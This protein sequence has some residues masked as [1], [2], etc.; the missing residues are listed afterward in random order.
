M[1]EAL[2]GGEWSAAHPG[3]TLSPGKTRYPLYRRLG[4]PQGRSGRA[5]N[6]IL[7]GIRSRTLQPVVQSLYRLSYRPINCMYRRLGV[8]LGRSG[9]AKNLIPTG[10]RSRTLQPVVQSLYRLS[11]PAHQLHVQ[12]AG[13]APGPVWTGGKSHLHRDSIPDPPARSSA[14]IPTELGAHQLQYYSYVYRQLALVVC[15]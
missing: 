10:I 11:Y 3:R 2:E 8:P 1:T 6:L 7:T 5:E 15:D 13:C 14:A 12:E 4:V 9:R